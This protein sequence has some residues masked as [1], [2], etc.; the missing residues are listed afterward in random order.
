MKN[1]YYAIKGFGRELKE[2]LVELYQDMIEKGK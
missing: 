2:A 1:L